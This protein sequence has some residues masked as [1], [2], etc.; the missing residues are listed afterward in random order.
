MQLKNKKPSV[1]R[2]LNAPT[3]VK[4]ARS[5]TARKRQKS[6]TTAKKRSRSSAAKGKTSRKSEKKTSSKK[7]AVASGKKSAKPKVLFADEPEIFCENGASSSSGVGFSNGHHDANDDAEASGM[8]NE[9][10]IHDFGLFGSNPFVS[11]TALP[12][13]NSEPFA[14]FQHSPF[15]KKRQAKSLFRSLGRTVESKVQPPSAIDWKLFTE[16]QD[17]EDDSTDPFAACNLG[18]VKYFSTFS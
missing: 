3:T 2:R 17:E 4:R 6:A 15:K 18:N 14:R 5:A 9:A 11:N 12:P 1:V 8:N 13:S 16:D 10:E 7:S